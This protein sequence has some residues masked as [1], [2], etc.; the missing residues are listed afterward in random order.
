MVVR[1]W[2]CEGSAPA[3][4]WGVTPLLGHGGDLAGTWRGHGRAR[5]WGTGRRVVET[6]CC[7]DVGAGGCGP[8]PQSLAE[9]SAAPQRGGWEALRC[10]QHGPSP[11]SPCR[12]VPPRA[13]AF[14]MPHPRLACGLS[15]SRLAKL[16]VIG[17]SGGAVRS[18]TEAG[19]KE[20]S[21]VGERG[22]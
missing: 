13:P 1:A 11:A 17:E 2:L 12:W 18:G 8:R 9:G 19:C 22:V 4:A 5:R 21:K 15:G 7:R 20:G 6:L 3:E 10:L 14:P 16:Q